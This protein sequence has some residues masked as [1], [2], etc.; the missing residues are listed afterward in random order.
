[1][2]WWGTG[3][4]TGLA[5]VYLRSISDPPHNGYVTLSKSLT[6]EC[7]F[8]YLY[9]RYRN[10]SSQG[11][12]RTTIFHKLEG[13]P[14]SPYD[15]TFV[16][17]FSNFSEGREGKRITRTSQGI[18]GPCHLV[19]TCTCY[20]SSLDG[21]KVPLP[22]H[23]FPTGHREPRSLAL[24]FPPPVPGPLPPSSHGP[25]LEGPRDVRPAGV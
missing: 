12:E 5:Q 3:L 22:P 11:S 1:M 4:S 14:R 10:T 17:S 2:G 18:P 8:P 20:I 15:L 13:L 25:H 16:A 7:H 21:V 23:T 19:H 9:N 24:K 6:S